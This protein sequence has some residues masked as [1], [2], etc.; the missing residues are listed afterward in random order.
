MYTLLMNVAMLTSLGLNETQAKTYIVLVKNGSLTPPELAK[1]LE[2]KRTNAYAVLDQLVELELASKQEQNKKNVY[3]VLNPIALERLAK[4]YRNEAMDR[5]RQVQASMPTLLNYFY[6]FSTQ[7]GIRFFQGT[8][9][10]RELYDDMLRTGKDLYLVRSPY[11]QDL[12]SSNFYVSYKEKRA[13]RGIKTYML[14]P[15]NNPKIWN[16][17][18]DSRYNMER[19]P[20]D[21][22]SYTA[23]AEICAYGDKV[24]IISFGDEAFGTL[25]DSP[26]VA[27]G[28]RQLFEL[29]KLGA[30]SA[31]RK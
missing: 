1:L 17:E 30:Q 23:N 29:A 2:I 13:K 12:M 28:F 14:N 16:E 24:S 4:K 10:I 22:A 6:T 31:K 25:I 5:E 20:I 19:T 18:T 7:P 27:E 8:D 9:G 21:P 15:A 3:T 11:D 26:Q